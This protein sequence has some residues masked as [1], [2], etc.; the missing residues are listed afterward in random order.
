MTRN[1]KIVTAAIA[2]VVTVGPAFAGSQLVASAGLTEEQ[3]QGMT[4]TEIA[5]H[6]FN[7][8]ASSA[9]RWDPAIEPGDAGFP[10]HLATSAGIAPAQ[11]TGMSLTE[12]AAVKFNNDS[13]PDDAQ[14]VTRPSTAVYASRSVGVSG[15]GY[16]RLIA[17]AGLTPA[18]A[19][20]MSLSEIA[21]YKFDRDG[22]N[23]H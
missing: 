8:D 12:I 15:P 17:S 5:Q 23:A 9:D 21:V 2:L 7:R 20:G 3:A 10:S 13:R 22:T 1:F 14:V 19:Q 16:D 4:L 11:A 6:K 18:E